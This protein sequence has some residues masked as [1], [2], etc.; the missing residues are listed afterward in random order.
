L[1]QLVLLAEVAQRVVAAE[2]EQSPDHARLVIVIDMQRPFLRPRLPADRADPALCVEHPLVV[3][4]RHPVLALEMALALRRLALR[5][6]FVLELCCPVPVAVRHLPSTNAVAVRLRVE[7]ST[8]PLRREVARDAIG[9]MSVGHAGS[10]V[11][12]IE[13]LRLATDLA[14]FHALIVRKRCDS[15][16]ASA[17]CT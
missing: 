13:R 12:L 17:A 14:L 7:R 16:A 4:E 10:S 11:E 8:G 3:R 9:A 6:P 15:Y 5:P 1:E 2:A